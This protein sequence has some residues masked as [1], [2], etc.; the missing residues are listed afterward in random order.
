MELGKMMRV[1]IARR[2]RKEIEEKAKLL[3]RR[4]SGEK[5]D[6]MEESWDELRGEVEAAPRKDREAYRESWVKEGS[7]CRA[8]LTGQLQWV[9]TNEH[10]SVPHLRSPAAQSQRTHAD[11]RPPPNRPFSCSSFFLSS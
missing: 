9:K 4:S 7:G 11:P 2:C 1:R 10:P 3:R 5:V 8:T 6:D